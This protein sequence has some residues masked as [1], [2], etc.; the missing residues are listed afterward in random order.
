MGP[1]FLF[2]FFKLSYATQVPDIGKSLCAVVDFEQS[3]AALQAVRC[4]KEQ[5]V[6]SGMR[7]ALLGPRVRRTLYKQDRPEDESVCDAESV[8]DEHVGE[9]G[10]AESEIEK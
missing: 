6:E 9:N 5:L 10:K 2:F 4:L 3:D 1:F 7:L 8:C